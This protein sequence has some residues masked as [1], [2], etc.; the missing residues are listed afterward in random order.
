MSSVTPIRERYLSFCHVF[1]VFLNFYLNVFYAYV[2][3]N[4]SIIQQCANL[5]SV[6]ISL[7]L[8]VTL[9]VSGH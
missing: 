5:P 8:R 1:A 3:V 2:W 4:D 9:L 6:K 7:D